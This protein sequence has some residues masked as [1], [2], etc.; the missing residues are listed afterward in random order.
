MVS[1]I[2]CGVEGAGI[3]RECSVTGELFYFFAILVPIL[4]FGLIYLGYA[5]I[6]MYN[7]MRRRADGAVIKGKTKSL[8]WGKMCVKLFNMRGG[9]CITQSSKKAMRLGL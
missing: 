9:I 2:G 5:R 6:D 4:P 1:V 3:I 8:H 7:G